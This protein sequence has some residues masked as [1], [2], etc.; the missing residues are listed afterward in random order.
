[1]AQPPGKVVEFVTT[2]SE[3]EEALVFKIMASSWSDSDAIAAHAGTDV[4]EENP[5]CQAALKMRTGVSCETRALPQVQSF[6]RRREST[7][8][9]I[10]NAPPAGWIPAFAGM[11]GVSKGIRRLLTFVFAE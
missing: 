3:E 8:H 7:P 11:T 2:L 1:M 10:G 6:P 9:A 4:N 5:C